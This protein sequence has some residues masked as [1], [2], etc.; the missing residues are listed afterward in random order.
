LCHVS[1]ALEPGELRM[2]LGLLALKTWARTAPARRKET[3][4]KKTN[5]IP[6]SERESRRWWEQVE[7][8]EEQVANR[9]CSLIHLMDSE[10]DAYPLFCQLVAARRRFVIRLH[11][12]RRVLDDEAKGLDEKLAMAPTRIR[13]A[14]PLSARGNIRGATGKGRHAPRVARIAELEISA[15]TVTLRAPA[16]TES[17]FPKTVTLTVIRVF[18]PNPPP[19]AEPVE[20]KL[21]TTEPIR[22]KADVEAIVDAY[23]ARW[24]VEE[25]FKALKTGCAF[26]TR[27]LES[28]DAITKALAIFTPIAY[29][30]LRLR[31]MARQEDPRP[32]RKAFRPSL[33][34][35]LRNHPQLRL[36]DD[37]TVHDAFLA[38]AQLGGH[39]KNNG[40]PGWRV[41]GRGYEKVLA[42]EIGV[43]IARQNYDQS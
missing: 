18:E 41:L 40:A 11:V 19:G 8:A 28:Y 31:T 10:A 29:E 6:A 32:A 15:S 9:G 23:R 16:G 30:M 20:W 17:A 37:S 21:A 43:L 7:V 25:Y 36:R 1:L 39:I 42:I 24:V 34:L 26:E 27:Q 22:T 2:P 38:I 14:V 33:W 3:K 35:V 4:S 5:D 13:R 12:D